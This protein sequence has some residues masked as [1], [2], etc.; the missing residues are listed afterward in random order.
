[1]PY[2]PIFIF[3]FLPSIIWLL[4]FLRRD[5]HP[6]SNRMILKIFFYGMAAAVPAVFLEIG[7]LQKLSE[8]SLPPAINS[9]IYLFCGIALVEE[10]LKYLAVK[11][12]VLNNPEFDEPPDAMLYM[13]ISALG[14]A[15][16]E[17]ILILLS[18]GKLYPEIGQ[19]FAV[20][21]LR[22][23]GA[24]L[25]HALCSASF[26]YFLALSFLKPKNKI[27]LAGAGLFM[28]TLLHGLFNFSIIITET[29]KEP[30]FAFPA[31]ILFSLAV[32]VFLGFGKLKKLSSV[33]EIKTSDAR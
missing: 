14:F 23:V 5:A 29:N 1:M 19:I 21:A 15:A 7:I 18:F 13:I 4:F 30:G 31:I 22:F 11:L 32:F 3:A 33:C 12:K 24:T 20:T 25:L 26:G 9:V 28:A 17:N 10:T 8:L 16:F 6:E 2:L 27:A